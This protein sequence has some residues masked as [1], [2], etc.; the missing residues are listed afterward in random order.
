MTRKTRK[1]K[2]TEILNHAGSVWQKAK[3]LTLTML[4]LLLVSVMERWGISMRSVWRHG[5]WVRERRRRL[6]ILTHTTGK[7]FHVNY[8][9]R[10]SL[11]HFSCRKSS[12]STVL[13]R[14]EHLWYWKGRQSIRRILRLSMCW[15]LECV[16]QLNLGEGMSLI[17]VFQISQY[18]DVM[19][20]LHTR[21][22]SFMLRT[23]NPSLAHWKDL[24]SHLNFSLTRDQCSK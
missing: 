6:H 23:L 13:L 8:A 5:W 24:W 15:T 7:N 9:K 1:R 2:Q 20:Q 14:M 10:Y 21:M 18:Q 12:V 16:N 17:Y 4:S 3:N 19:Q 22:E 11:R